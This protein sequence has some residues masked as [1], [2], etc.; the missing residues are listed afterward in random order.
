MENSI[1]RN[2]KCGEVIHHIDLDKT[3]N[4][5]ENLHLFKNQNEH[6]K[7][8]IQL[9]HVGAELFKRGIIGFE[10]GKYFIK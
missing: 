3:N 8:H 10:D 4:S 5:I 1:G 9:E 7:C 2:L 6:Q